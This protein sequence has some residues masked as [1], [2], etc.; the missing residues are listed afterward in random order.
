MDYLIEIDK[1]R[2]RA[3]AI[4]QEVHKP[5]VRIP[6]IVENEEDWEFEFGKTQDGKIIMAVF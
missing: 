5:V 3:K 1:A 4:L 2:D 6:V